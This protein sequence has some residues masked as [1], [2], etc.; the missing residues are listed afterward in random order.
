VHLDSVIFRDGAI[1]GPD[2]FHHFTLIQDRYNAVRK[3][4]AAVVSAQAA[5]EDLQSILA[6]IRKNAES[7]PDTNLTRRASRVSAWC[8]TLLQ[9]VPDPEGI[10][11]QLKEQVAPP[12]FHHLDLEE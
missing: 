8:A 9:S 11:A 7:T 2:K 1:L 6:R 4:V 12:S 5:G 3:F 10:L